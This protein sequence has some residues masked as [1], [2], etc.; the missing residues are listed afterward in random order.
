MANL[1]RDAP[2]SVANARRRLSLPSERRFHQEIV[3]LSE[4][5]AKGKR[6]S[7]KGALEQFVDS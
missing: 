3:L 5:R 7:D 2:V 6:I 1:T 4:G